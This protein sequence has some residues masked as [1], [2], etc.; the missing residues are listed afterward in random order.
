MEQ[1]FL[2]KRAADGKFIYGPNAR[3]TCPAGHHRKK[4]TDDNLALTIINTHTGIAEDTKLPITDFLKEN[5]TPYT[6]LDEFEAAVDD[7]F[8]RVG[9]ERTKKEW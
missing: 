9:G 3:C 1:K 2:F 8:F 4:P 7:F 5:G 6:D